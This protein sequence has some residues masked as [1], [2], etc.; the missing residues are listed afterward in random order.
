M[1]NNY[2]LDTNIQKAT[3]TATLW[4]TENGIIE[5]D[6]NTLAI[7]IK[8]KDKPQGFVFHGKCKLLLDTIVE[9]DKGAIGTPVEKLMT[10]PFIMLGDPERAQQHLAA[11][12]KEDLGKMSYETEQA[13]TTKAQRLCDQFFKRGTIHCSSNNSNAGH[14]VVFA[15]PNKAA[16]FDV[17]IANGSKL[18]YKAA[19]KVFISNED[20]AIL[21]TSEEMAIAKNGK[22]F[23]LKTRF[24]S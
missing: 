2:C 13:F 22:S 23:V 17:L 12:S 9:T 19:D 4:K 16:R 24:S 10:E 5:I 7:A 1:W 21:K 8:H 11:A 18:V 20:K 14:G 6:K 3:E 15:F